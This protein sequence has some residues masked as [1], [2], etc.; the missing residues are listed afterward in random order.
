MTHAPVISV[1]DDDESVRESLQAL[2]R[3]VGFQVKVFPSAEEFLHS[4]HLLNTDCLILDVRM[5]GM[6]GPELQ[7]EL[8][9]RHLE[10][11][12]IFMTA[13]ESDEE[14]RAR[15]LRNGAVEYLIKPVSEKVLLNAMDSALGSK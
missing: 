5:P 8:K 13:H 1:V 3:S 9:A 6:S 11:P 4:E 12:I 14:V 7:G 2:I 10:V 15:A